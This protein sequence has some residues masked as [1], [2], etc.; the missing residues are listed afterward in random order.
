MKDKLK[1]VF[2]G[3]FTGFCNGL[4]GSGGGM[5]AVPC[6]EK[7]AKL[8]VKKAHA[9][10]ILIILPL[11]VISLFRYSAGI[12]VDFNKLITIVIGGVLGSFF[13]ARWLKKLSGTTLKRVFAVFILIAAVRMVIL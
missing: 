1:L 8:E 10:A 12:S 13:G 5:I 9:T 3:V 2:F 4:F 6:L 7:Y 11:S